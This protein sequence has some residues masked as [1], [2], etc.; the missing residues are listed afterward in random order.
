MDIP[1]PPGIL[2]AVP[3]VYNIDDEVRDEGDVEVG[4]A[5]EFPSKCHRIICY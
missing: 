1:L 5:Q 2:P 4:L 3:P